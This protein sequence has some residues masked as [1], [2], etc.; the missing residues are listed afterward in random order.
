MP[1]VIQSTV[2]INTFATCF[3]QRIAAGSQFDGNAPADATHLF[4]K[5]VNTDDG[6]VRYKYK[7]DDDPAHD[8]IKGTHGGLFEWTSQMP[9]ALEE[10]IA[11]FG[12]NVTWTLYLLTTTGDTIQLLTGTGRYIL[13]TEYERFYLF[14]GE[15]LKLVTKDATADM[16]VRLTLSLDSGIT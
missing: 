2:E 1:D 9:V 16:F 15:K 4:Q 7:P 5:Y 8:V 14:R 3:E 12:G 13:R 6:I 10:I 11:D